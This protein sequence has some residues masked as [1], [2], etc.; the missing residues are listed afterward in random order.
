MIRGEEVG[1][2]NLDV[3]RSPITALRFSLS[4]PELPGYTGARAKAMRKSAGKKGQCCGGSRCLA[5]CGE[6]CGG[7]CKGVLAVAGRHAWLAC[8]SGACAGRAAAVLASMCLPKK[9]IEYSTVKPTV[10]LNYF[11]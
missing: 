11:Y 8:F 7:R 9:G 5:G 10:N 6:C 1:G 2:N 4:G 3:T